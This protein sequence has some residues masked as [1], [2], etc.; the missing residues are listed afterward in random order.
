MAKRI[1]VVDDDQGL[2]EVLKTTLTKAGYR[3]LTAYNGEEALEKIEKV[4]PDL[5][6]LDVM[7]PK[8]DGIEVAKHLLTFVSGGHIP[9][10]FLTVKSNKED[11][12]KCYKAGADW[13]LAKPFNREELLTAVNTLLS[14]GYYKDGR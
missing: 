1:L 9:I 10:I 14:P 11:V 3:I 7:M 4:I 12:E 2:V 5:I 8:M 6:I 13:Y